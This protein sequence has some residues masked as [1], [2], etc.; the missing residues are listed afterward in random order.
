MQATYLNLK[1]I[2]VVTFLKSKNEQVKLIL[3]IKCI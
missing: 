2:I 3:I 1:F